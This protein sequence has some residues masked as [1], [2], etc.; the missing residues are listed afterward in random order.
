MT[1]ETRSAPTDADLFVA[2][3]EEEAE[4]SRWKLRIYATVAT[5]AGRRTLQIRGPA[6]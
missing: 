2:L 6:F 5:P 3:A 1:V 4:L